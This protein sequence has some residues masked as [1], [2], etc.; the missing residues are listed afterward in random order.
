MKSERKIY[1][2]NYVAAFAPYASEFH[3]EAWVFTKRHIDN[4]DEMNKHELKSF[5]KA[6]KKILTKLGALDLSYNYFL[7]QLISNRDQH[8]YLKI[9]PR[10]SIWAGIELGSGLV[11]NSISPEVAAKYYRE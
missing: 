5:S 8:L 9:Q 10:D 1:E 7:H 3:Y 11:I 6:M 4:V 2:D